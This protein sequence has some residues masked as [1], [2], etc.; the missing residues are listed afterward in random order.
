[1]TSVICADDDKYTQI[2]YQSIFSD[3]GYKVRVYSDSNA[4][5][6][7]Y[8]EEPADVLILDIHMPGKSG[9]DLCRE[10][11]K[12]AETFDVPIIIVSAHDT[13]EF[14]VEGLSAG[15]DDY[16]IKPF[17]L[18]E[19]LAKTSAVVKKRELSISR[20]SGLPV[21]CLFAGRYEVIREIG[22]GGFSNVYQAKDIGC[23]RQGGVALKVFEVPPSMQNDQEF[24]ATFLREAYGLS[25]LDNPNIVKLYDFGHTACYYYLV[26]EYLEGKTLYHIVKESG[27]MDEEEVAL[28]AYEVSKT[29][30]HLESHKLVHRDIKPINIMIVT[31]GNVKL[32]DFGLARN[33]RDGN[34]TIDGIFK[35]TPQYAAPEVI[36]MESDI[37]IR[38]D[39]FSLGATLYHAI[40]HDNPFPGRTAIEVFNNRFTETPTPIRQ[41]NP[42]IS[43]KFSDLID[44]M[45]LQEKEKRPTL[46][47]V[48]FVSGGIASRS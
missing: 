22:S 15:A 17:K 30:Q 37:D 29:L 43:L 34:I 33:V 1:M 20:G 47:E 2:L 14:I 45:L 32:I 4:V 10:F 35:G 8:A 25:K 12:N 21:G 9:L 11:R 41:I 46:S 31:T 44:R 23:D 27:A 7:A 39:I 38:A 19:L 36:R 24:M 16:I 18:A 6:K 48:M 5:S 40:T 13:E 3:R 42:E 28:I 26:M